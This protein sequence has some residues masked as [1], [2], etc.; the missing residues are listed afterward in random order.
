MFASST[1]LDG[2]DAD[3]LATAV[4]LWLDSALGFS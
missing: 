4:E 3:E 2:P 1:A